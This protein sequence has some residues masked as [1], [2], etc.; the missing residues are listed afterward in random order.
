MLF[1]HIHVVTDTKKPI[2]NDGDKVYLNELYSNT[3]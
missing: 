1:R 3:I 2:G